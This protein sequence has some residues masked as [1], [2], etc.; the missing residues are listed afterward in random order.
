MESKIF[1]D[2]SLSDLDDLFGLRQVQNNQYLDYWTQAAQPLS[3][4]EKNNAL[5]LQN[6]LNKNT[7]V[8]NEQELSLHFIGPMFSLIDFTEPYRF[9]LFAQRY[10]SATVN[11]ILL[12]GKPDGLIASGYR[13]PEK[14]FFCFHEYKKEIDNSGDPA[15][16]CLAAMLVGQTLNLPEKKI[17]YGCYVIGRDWYFMVLDDK[18][19]AISNVYSATTPAIFN[20]LQILKTL[21]QI[22]QQIAK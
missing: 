4:D 1:N 8:W 6:L 19:Y 21:L 7:S 11:D 9:N 3:N 17:I 5:R 14:P 15:G 10:I 13:N 2:C 20:I 12:S 18:Q 16:Q 22:I